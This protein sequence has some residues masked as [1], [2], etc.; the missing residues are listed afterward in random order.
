MWAQNATRNTVE[1]YHKGSTK[2]EVEKE[3]TGDGKLYVWSEEN[4]VVLDNAFAECMLM[5]DNYMTNRQAEADPVESS[6]YRKIL[7]ETF[8]LSKLKRQF[9][10]PAVLSYDQS[11][12]SEAALSKAD[13]DKQP[14]TFWKFV[15]QSLPQLSKLALHLFQIAVNPVAV[16]SLFS[17]FGN[18]QT[19][20]KNSFV[21]ARLEKLAQIKAML[22]PKLRPVSK[23]PAGNQHLSTRSTVRDEETSNAELAEVTRQ[24]DSEYADGA[25]DLMVTGEQ[26]MAEYNLQLSED[27]KDDEDFR[28]SPNK[29]SLAVLFVDVP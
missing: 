15:I 21:L 10:D 20:L 4:S 24:N 11:R 7:Y 23:Q 18:V 28:P 17:A 5:D 25:D 14:A 1:Q 2:A 26:L 19:N 13:P 6:S 9:L 3:W 29:I 27:A 8:P 22:P 12:I 16:E